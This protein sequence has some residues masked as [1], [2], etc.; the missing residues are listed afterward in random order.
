LFGD[1][2]GAPDEQLQV[3]SSEGAEQPQLCG[4]ELEQLATFLSSDVEQHAPASD[5][6]D[7]PQHPEPPQLTS[8]PVN[9]A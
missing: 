7:V 4:S 9:A 8:L 6:A 1:F 3:L 2:T 5:I